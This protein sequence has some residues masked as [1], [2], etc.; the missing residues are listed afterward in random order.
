[1]KRPGSNTWV[2]LLI[3]MP[4]I[5]PSSHLTHSFIDLYTF[6]GSTST[7]Q[8]R[9]LLARIKM[10]TMQYFHS[11]GVTP[12]YVVLPMNTEFG[13][14]NLLDP[15]LIDHFEKNWKGIYLVDRLGKVQVFD[16]EV[17][18]S[19]V[20]VVNSFENDTGVVADFCIHTKNFFAHNPLMDIDR[21]VNKTARDTWP[22]TSNVLRILFHLTGPLAGKTT[23]ELLFTGVTDKLFFD[24]P[25]VN[26]AFVGL[27]HCI[28]YA[29]QWRHNGEDFASVAVMKHNVCEKTKT[30]WNRNGTYPGEPFFV[31]SGA[32]VGEDDGTLI[33]VA[34]D[35]QKRVSIFVTLDAKTMKELD[36]VELTGGFIPFTAHGTFVPAK[37]HSA[38]ESFV[39]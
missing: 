13:M 33:F 24:F 2:A 26:P 16:T 23:N 18:F 38:E 20:H 9:N 39:V 14:F 11:Y 7:P 21:F 28:Y 34:L 37:A 25:K 10:D 5:P 30:Y 15:T 36:V 27:P 12:N 32:S 6:D 31:S 3:E 35:G 8:G 4:L 29:V 17:T 19:H 22:E 1:V